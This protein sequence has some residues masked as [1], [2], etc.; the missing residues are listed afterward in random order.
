MCERGS[1][2]Q[3]SQSGM[4]RPR[5]RFYPTHLDGVRRNDL[6]GAHGGGTSRLLGFAPVT[7]L[8]P[9][10]PCGCNGLRALLPCGW[11]GLHPLWFT[12]VAALPPKRPRSR[13]VLRLLQTPGHDVTSSSKFWAS[14]PLGFRQ[15]TAAC[16]LAALIALLEYVEH[17]LARA[18][19]IASLAFCYGLTWVF[20]VD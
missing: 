16:P 5:E 19:A 8:R 6:L 15:L 10:R 13:A 17:G 12:H 18:F 2:A 11:R 3:A 4:R 20:T 7:A 14:G 9:K 1:Y